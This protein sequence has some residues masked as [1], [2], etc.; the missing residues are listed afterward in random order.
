MSVRHAAAR[1]SRSHSHSH[2]TA[3]T[4]IL[5]VMVTVLL[6]AAIFPVRQLLAERAHTSSLERQAQLLE[7]KKARLDARIQRY[8]DPI[9]LERLARECL[10]MVKPGEV[11]FVVVPKGGGAKPAAC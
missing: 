2:F 4:A 6:V 7:R 3:R 10:G 1:R 11:A 8:H 9:Y 5:A